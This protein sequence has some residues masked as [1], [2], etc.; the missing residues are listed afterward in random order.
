MARRRIRLAGGLRWLLLL[1]AKIVLK[2]AAQASAKV[3]AK[4]I[5]TLGVDDSRHS[6]MQTTSTSLAQVPAPPQLMM[7]RLATPPTG[8]K[9]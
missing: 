2:C 6:R 9:A 1:A 8:M 4:P 5:M 7:L 3:S